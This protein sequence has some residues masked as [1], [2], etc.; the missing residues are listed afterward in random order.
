[1]AF[2]FEDKSITHFSSTRPEH[3]KCIK[4]DG[5][6]AICQVFPSACMCNIYLFYKS[7][8]GQFFMEGLWPKISFR[9]T[10]IMY[11]NFAG[12]D[13]AI[14]LPQQIPENNFCKAIQA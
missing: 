12:V 8:D 4:Y 14:A 7:Y 6:L 2:T 5:V 11:Y 3:V 1:M 13:W 9:L 10:T